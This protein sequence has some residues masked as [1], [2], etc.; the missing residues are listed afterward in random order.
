MTSRQRAEG[1]AAF[2]MIAIG[3]RQPTPRVPRTHEDS[4]A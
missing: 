4:T 2:D 1:K 3:H